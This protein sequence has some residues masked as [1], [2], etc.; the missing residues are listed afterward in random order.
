MFQKKRKGIF[1]GIKANDKSDVLIRFP[2]LVKESSDLTTHSLV[3]GGQSMTI[4]HIHPDCTE[5]ERLEKLRA[6]KR[7]CTKILQPD[8][9]EEKRAG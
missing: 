7:L 4:E 5:E 9:R 3:A 2:G 8:E 6:I 1:T